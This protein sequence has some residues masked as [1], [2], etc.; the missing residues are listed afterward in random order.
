MPRVKFH[1]RLPG[2][3]H[4]SH[5]C[6]KGNFSRIERAGFFLAAVA[7]SRVLLPQAPGLVWR[8]DAAVAQILVPSAQVQQSIIART[9]L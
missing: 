7:F 5:I 6:R 4:C 3:A 2:A 8:F 9:V 1:S